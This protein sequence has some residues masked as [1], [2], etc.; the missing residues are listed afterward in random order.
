MVPWA[1]NH[2]DLLL[3]IILHGRRKEIS[4]DMTYQTPSKMV[5]L[6]CHCSEEKNRAISTAAMDNLESKHYV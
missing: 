4:A 5:D 2:L 6:Q 3:T 1:R